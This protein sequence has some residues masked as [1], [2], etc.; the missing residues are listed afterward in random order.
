MGCAAD[1]ANMKKATPPPLSIVTT[2]HIGRP[3]LNILRVRCRSAEDFRSLYCS[4]HP[5]GGLFCATTTELVPETP[6]VIEIACKG[7]PNKVL[8]RGVVVF[9]RP[10]SPR[11]GIR[12]G[13]LV[14][15]APEEAGKREFM[16]ETLMGG[17]EASPRR[18]HAR[19]PVRMPAKVRIGNN[20]HATEAE[21][22]EIGVSGALFVTATLPAV[23]TDVV[24]DIVPPGAVAPMSIAGRVLYHAGPCQAGV[25]FREGSGSRR[26]RELVRRFKL[27]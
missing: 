26:L 3:R 23:G 10:A 14:R 22:C 7:L 27:P 20:L 21:L 8:V 15:F 1:E 13:A 9:W 17:R 5:D 25:M 4:D 24:I 18:K 11:L 2:I 19:I 16:L 12:A 6:V